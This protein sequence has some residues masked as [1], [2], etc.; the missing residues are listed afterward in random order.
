[1][2]TTPVKYATTWAVT[3]IAYPAEYPSNA[4]EMMINNDFNWAADNY[5]RIIDEWVK[6]FDGKSDAK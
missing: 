4:V 2:K 3:L 5:A 6:R 1:M